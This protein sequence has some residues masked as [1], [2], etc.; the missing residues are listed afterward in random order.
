[1]WKR[2]WLYV[3]LAVT[4]LVYAQDEEELKKAEAEYKG[5]RPKFIPSARL[6]LSVELW[7]A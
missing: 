6:R 2:S 1:M 5:K 7:G 3:F 4:P